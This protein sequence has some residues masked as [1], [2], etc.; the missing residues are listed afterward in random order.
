MPY[1]ESMVRLIEE[2]SQLAGD[3]RV[4]ISNAGGN[5]QSAVAPLT[6]AI[7]ADP[8]IAWAAAAGLTGAA[9]DPAADPDHDGAVNL[10]EFAYGTSPAKGGDSPVFS[11]AEVLVGNIP[12][13]TVTWTRRKGL[14]QVRI[15]LSVASSAD[16]TDDL[17]STTVSVTSLA[18]GLER[19]VT[20]SDAAGPAQA[21]Q[22]FRFTVRR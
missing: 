12:Y 2:F 6:V 3:Y 8:F 20:R 10:A 13:P 17:G 4:V 11:V 21:A 9:A 1:P 5:V 18:D 22:F 7:A 14:G 19:V 16:F 15:E